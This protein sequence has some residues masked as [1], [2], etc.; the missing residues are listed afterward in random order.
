[1]D[2]EQAEKSQQGDV[3]AKGKRSVALLQK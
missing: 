3:T 2:Q 1:M